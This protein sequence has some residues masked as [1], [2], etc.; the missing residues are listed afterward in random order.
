LLFIHYT[1]VIHEKQEDSANVRF[2]QRAEGRE[3]EVSETYNK[4]A[5][6]DNFSLKNH[7]AEKI[8]FTRIPSQNA[9]SRILMTENAEKRKKSYVKC[10]VLLIC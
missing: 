10:Y 9:L 6:W 4:S 7:R 2:A 3:P 8:D 1:A 5:I